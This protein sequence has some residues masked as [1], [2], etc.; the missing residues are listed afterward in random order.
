MALHTFEKALGIY[1]PGLGYRFLVVI[2]ILHLGIGFMEQCL[3][4]VLQGTS[5]VF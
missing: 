5:P 2:I 4:L 1:C 3:H